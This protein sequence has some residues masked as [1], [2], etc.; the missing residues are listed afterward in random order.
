MCRVC[1]REACSECIKE[2]K[3]LTFP[4]RA[5]NDKGEKKMHTNHVFLTCCKRPE[6]SFIDFS[7][8]TRFCVEELDAEVKQ[9]E[10][11]LAE[12][13][14]RRSD[15]PPSMDTGW[16]KIDPLLRPVKT[17]LIHESTLLPE[18]ES[19]TLR[20]NHVLDTPSREHSSSV[21]LPDPVT[22]RVEDPSDLAGVPRVAYHVFNG[23]LSDDQFRAVW[24]QGR[25]L[26]VTG[27]LGNFKIDW[28]PEYFM[29]YYEKT[30]CSVLECH[31]NENKYISVGEFFAQFGKQREYDAESWK[32][33]VFHYT[34][35]FLS[36]YLGCFKDWPPSADFKQAFPDLYI[37]FLSAVPV[38]N[39]T[40]RDGSLTIAAHFPENSIPPDL[41]PKMYNALV[42]SISSDFYFCTK[43]VVYR[44]PLNNP[45]KKAVHA[46]I[47]IWR[48]L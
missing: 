5:V 41:G 34:T 28:T 9:M 35:C 33:K 36:F 26:V 6:H 31:T 24:S 46:Y 19:A 1:G 43:L 7:P 23:E 8:V 11:F 3:E 48:M 27:L 30:Q 25:P 42:N 20:L 18:P 37:D 45:A 40:R 2:V 17:N 44:R 29:H 38:P 21:T 12:Y 22:G 32:L 13:G 47:W 39:Y 10:Q 16:D 4:I 15:S 14:E